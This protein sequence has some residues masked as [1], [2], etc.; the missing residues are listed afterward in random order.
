MNTLF[1]YIARYQACDQ[2][3]I[4]IA[5]YASLKIIAVAIVDMIDELDIHT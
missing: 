2:L 4:D 1:L 3:P 5:R